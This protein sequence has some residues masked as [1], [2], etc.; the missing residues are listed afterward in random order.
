MTEDI[1]KIKKMLDQGIFS[2][3][4]M[5]EI[6]SHYQDHPAIIP[7]TILKGSKIIRSNLNGEKQFHESVSRLSYPPTQYARTDRASLEGK[8]MFYGC[9]FTS[10]AKENALPRIFSALETTDILR[11]YEAT[12]RTFTTQSLWLPDRDLHLF[13]FPFS[14]NYARPCEEVSFQRK[15]WDEQL[16]KYWSDEYVIFS[17]YIGDLLAEENHSC[18]YDI[19]ANTIDF[20]LNKSTAASDLDGIIYPS[21]WGQGQGMNICLRKEVV[22]ESVHFQ[23]ASV[24]YIEKRKGES[25]IFG[26]A[27]SYLCP[28][29]DL[30]WIP[31]PQAV[32][33]LNAVYGTK[34]L[35][36]RG[37]IYFGKL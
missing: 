13:S 35:L 5:E 26:V 14:K 22:D 6:L 8:P 16:K 37:V 10:A 1:C 7:S 21:V 27:D 17:E 2:N 33:I 4:V 32:S 30:K 3:S 11:D 9:V 25:K 12:G 24:Q 31:T 18:L 23:M 20:I 28:N 29:G 19:T 34:D 36:K 15:V